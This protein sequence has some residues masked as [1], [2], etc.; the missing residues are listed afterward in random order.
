MA[1]WNCYSSISGQITPGKNE[2]SKGVKKGLK[3]DQTSGKFCLLRIVAYQINDK[4]RSVMLSM[5][6]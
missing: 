3:F 4:G 2:Y 5:Q 6:I 1:D